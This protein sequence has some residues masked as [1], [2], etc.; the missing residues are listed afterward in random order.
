[1]GFKDKFILRVWNVGVVESGIEEVFNRPGSL[2]IR[3]VKHKYRDRF[4]ADP[5]LLDQDQ[6]Y[7]YI[8]VEE[9]IFCREKGRITCLTVDKKTM[10]LVNREI[11]L[12]EGHHLSYPFVFG[13]YIIPEGHRSG[14]AY[15][16]KKADGGE[17]YRKIKI[18]ENAL[19]DPTLLYYGDRY[20]IFATT[21]K[22]QSDAVTKLSIFHSDRLGAFASHEKN[23]VKNDIKSARPGGRFFEYQGRLF[24]PAMDSE[25]LYGHLIR[26]MEVKKLTVQDYEEQEVLVLSSEHA[27][28]CNMGLHTFNVYENCIIVDGYREYYSYFMKPVIVKLKKIMLYL[29]EKYDNKGKEIIEDTDM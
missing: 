29:Y 28:P 6:K 14:A 7:Y 25:K 27:P 18:N 19:I 17:R 15:A 26:I 9:Y 20:W 4:F 12:N 21:K 2:K 8:L 22:I 16:Y 5:F 10:K 24:R 1:M 23:P 11:I 3:W 13:D